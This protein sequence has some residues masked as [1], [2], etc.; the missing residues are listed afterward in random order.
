MSTEAANGAR[1]RFGDSARGG[2][3]LGLGMRQALPLVLGVLW[4]TLWLMI[5]LPIVGLLGPLAAL[6]C[7]FGRWR[8]APLHDVAVPGLGLAWRRWRR[9]EVWTTA[10]LL[11]VVA[12][13]DELPSALRGLELVEVP[14]DRPDG[15]A[16]VVWDR[17]ATTMSVVIPV[18]GSG[19]SVASLGEQDAWVAAWGAALAPLARARCPVS[20]FTWQEWCHPV[21]L[22]GHLDF[23]AGSRRTG[24]SSSAARCDYDELLA[25]QAASTVA[26]EVLLTVTVDA[27]RVHRTRRGGGDNA[28][29][30]ALFD[31]VGQLTARLQT[32]GLQAGRPLGSYELSMAVRARSDPRTAVG[33]GT[34][35]R[36]LAAAVGKGHIE[37]GP[38]A[39]QPGWDEVRVDCSFHRSYRVAAWPMLPVTAD[40]L[41][42]LLMGDAATRTVTVVMEPVPLARAALDANR[43]LTSIEADHDQK[44]RHGFRLTARERRQ[45]ADV[46]AREHELASGHP[47]FRH[48]AFVHV[49]A[50][51]LAELEESAAR[52]EQA[53]AQSMLDLRPL[54][55]RHDQGWVASLPLG[56][57]ARTGGR[58]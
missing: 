25:D 40:W 9:S 12:E 14:V 58:P 33:F 53:G 52:V 2:V 50:G 51:S 48:V 8:R 4:L 56:R 47:E 31:E 23:L 11:G 16:V 35:G 30:G 1:Y 5:Q 7:A 15:G 26:H 28:A 37:W 17:W 43:R 6:V 54:A 27:T 45:H 32:A 24:R 10:S 36:S 22:T 13:V 20:R 19:F 42:P 41:A 34:R 44:Q 55:A 39:V 18:V 57:S 3:L 38:M 29:I 49:T 21:G 46:E